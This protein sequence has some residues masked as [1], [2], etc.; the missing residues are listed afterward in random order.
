MTSFSPNAVSG[1]RLAKSKTEKIGDRTLWN[2]PFADQY[3]E[4]ENFDYGFGVV[5]ISTLQSFAVGVPETDSVY[6]RWVDGLNAME[7]GRFYHAIRYFSRCLESSDLTKQARVALL[8][9]RGI[10][11]L[12]MPENLAIAEC[13]LVD[14]EGREFSDDGRDPKLDE[15]DKAIQDFNQA[16]ALDPANGTVICG[17]G[18]AFHRKKEI[19]KAIEFFDEALELEPHNPSILNNLGNAYA[20]W[21]SN[22]EAVE[23]YSQALAL[24]PDF[25]AALYNRGVIYGQMSAFDDAIADLDA[26]IRL[27]PD[28]QETYQEKARIFEHLGDQD[29][30]LAEYRNAFDRR[31]NN[32]FATTNYRN[33]QVIRNLADH[34][35]LSLQERFTAMRL[36]DLIGTLPLA[37]QFGLYAVFNIP[38]IAVVLLT[39]VGLALIEQSSPQTVQDVQLWLEHVGDLIDEHTVISVI[40]MLVCLVLSAGLG[41]FRHLCRRLILGTLPL[42]VQDD[43][44]NR[45]VVHLGTNPSRVWFSPLFRVGTWVLVAILTL[46]FGVLAVSILTPLSPTTSGTGWTLAVFFVMYVRWIVSAIPAWIEAK[47]LSEDPFP[48]MDEDER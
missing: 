29:R 27:N 19:D 39:Y 47:R 17:L 22:K 8:C 40:L 33:Y 23:E 34:G 10:S 2:W 46:M 3:A 7:A 13:G 36:L 45:K 31:R 5:R 1:F 35:R 9:N 21:G 11:Y 24:Q 42:Q 26:A 15:P 4:H 20:D 28:P 14:E 38:V 37:C 48:W 16:Y 30:A 32:C 18:N 25:Y 43:E 41:A 44:G 12:L 6:E